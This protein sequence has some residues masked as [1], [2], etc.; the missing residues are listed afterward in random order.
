[1][2]CADDGDVCDVVDQLAPRGLADAGTAVVCTRAIP[3]N[4]VRRVL[5]TLTV[6]TR[7]FIAARRARAETIVVHHPLIWEPKKTRAPLLHTKIMPRH[8]ASGDRV[9]RR[10]YEPRCCARGREHRDCGLLEAA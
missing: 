9:L 10:A 8:R 2:E 5:V 4:D 3:K 1:M 7:A 6:S